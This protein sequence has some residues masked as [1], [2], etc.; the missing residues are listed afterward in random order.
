M[1]KVKE[2]KSTLLYGFGHRVFKAH[3]PRAKILK[4]MLLDFSKR[5]D[6]GEN[7]L[8]TIA[9]ELEKQALADDYFKSRNLFPNLDFYS[10]LL[11]QSIHIPDNMFNVIFAVTRSI[12]W[13]SH[14]REMMSDP[15]IKIYRPRQVYVGQPAREF[16]DIKNRAPAPGFKLTSYTDV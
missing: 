6:S 10:G 14:W 12:G 9:L 2:D 7:K 3:D 11:M 15:V 1:Q 13:I 8:L 4:S 5:I 16:V